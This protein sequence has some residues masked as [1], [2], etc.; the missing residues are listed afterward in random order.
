MISDGIDPLSNA[1]KAVPVGHGSSASA[2][3]TAHYHGMVLVLTTL[4][5]SVQYCCI[6]RSIAQ[7]TPK[8]IYFYYQKMYL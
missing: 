8:N 4:L 2:S 1:L 5:S 6:S 3:E 7:V